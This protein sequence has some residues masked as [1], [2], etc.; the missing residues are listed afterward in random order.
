MRE[1]SSQREGKIA[2]HGSAATVKTKYVKFNGVSSQETSIIQFSCPEYLARLSGSQRTLKQ[3]TL[4][5]ETIEPINH[6]PNVC[7]SWR[8]GL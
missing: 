4:N 6:S 2:L 7:P 1:H 8:Y 5:Q 3:C